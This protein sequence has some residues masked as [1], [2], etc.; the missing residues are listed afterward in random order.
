M[1]KVICCVLVTIIYAFIFID[2]KKRHDG[3]KLELN[4]AG[5]VLFM[6]CSIMFVPN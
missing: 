3:S 2:E 5:Y 6:L 4:V 1:N